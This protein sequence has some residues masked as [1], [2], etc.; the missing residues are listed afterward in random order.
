ML[1]VWFILILLI[2]PPNNW[3]SHR[4]SVLPLILFAVIHTFSNY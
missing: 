2:G 1:H 3:M 4:D